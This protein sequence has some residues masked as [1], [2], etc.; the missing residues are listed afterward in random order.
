MVDFV[1]C[2]CDESFYSGNLN[3]HMKKCKD[4]IEAA[5]QQYA[6]RLSL[7]TNEG[8]MIV[9]NAHEKNTPGQYQHMIY[10]DTSSRLVCF[11]VRLFFVFIHFQ[12]YAI[13]ISRPDEY[14]IDSEPFGFVDSNKTAPVLITRKRKGP[15]KAELNIKY[16]TVD[17]PM[18]NDAQSIFTGVTPEGEIK[19][20]LGFI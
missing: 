7:K 17:N 14:T 9:L 20:M 10:N 4:A 11:F 12:A 5:L 2:A 8:M 19:I 3:G 13:Q 1:K 16:M 18:D 6:D 15:M